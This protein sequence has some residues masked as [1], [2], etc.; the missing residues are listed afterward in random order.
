MAYRL[1]FCAQGNGP[2]D[3]YRIFAPDGIERFDDA[4]KRRVEK[5]GFPVANIDDIIG[6]K[7]AANRQKDRE[8]LS[9]LISFRDWLRKSS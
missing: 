9:R 5:H 3:L 2:F 8:S 6:G 1:A 7:R 4:C